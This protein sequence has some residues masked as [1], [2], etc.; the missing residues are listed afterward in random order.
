MTEDNVL[1]SVV[2][3]MYNEEEAITEELQTIL[4]TMED[5]NLSYEIIVVDDGSTDRSPEIAKQFEDVQMIR[6][7]Y[8]R[9]TGAARTTG[10]KAARG[11]IVVMTDADGTYPGRDIPKLLTYILE[12]DFDMVIG[13]R[14][15]EK[16]TLRWLRS[17]TKWF[18]RRLASY[19]MNIPIPD[20]NS[21]FRAF[22]REIAL[23]Y[24]N[25]LPTTHSWVSTITLAFLS[26]RHPVTWMPI[27]YFPRKGQSTFHPI[28]DTYNYLTLVVRTTTYFR[29]LKVFL[30]IALV[31][32]VLGSVKA[33][34]DIAVWVV[35]QES[36]LLMITAG[37]LIGMMGLLADLI[38]AQHRMR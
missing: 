12:R 18:I 1:V 31:L 3:P 37:L 2:I 32:I 36:E 33:I 28:A 29:P 34:Y 30:P 4:E 13:A 26:D 10:L 20:L 23:H 24:L 21:G 25:I 14:R 27:D 5:S 8:N 19:L 22:R 15:S 16:G 6:H 9:G 35:L 17:P 38:V 11:E 7:P